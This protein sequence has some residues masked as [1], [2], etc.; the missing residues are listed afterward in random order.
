MASETH[1][2]LDARS[3]SQIRPVKLRDLVPHPKVQ[4]AFRAG[5][6]A[7]IAGRLDLDALGYPVVSRHGN[8]YHVIDGQHRVEALKLFGFL[9]DDLVECQVYVDLTEQQEAELFLRRNDGKAV[10]A[11]SGFH[12]A[13][14][15]G[16]A[17]ETTISDVVRQLG[18]RIGHR[19]RGRSADAISAVGTLKAVYGRVGDSGLAKTLRIIRDAYG[20]AALEAPIIDGLGLC[21]QR[22][23]GTLDEDTMITALST[24]AGGLHGLVN[25][26]E[27][28]RVGMGQSRQQCIA[29]TAVDLY[30]RAHGLKKG[31]LA[32]WWKE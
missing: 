26:A 8:I 23:D 12:V 9:P 3:P 11:L 32:P 15:A 16:R 21:V 17:D 27:K 28:T 29:A 24:A 13:I 22:Y 4:R 18:L 7:K 30:N 1:A 10:D 14:H 5:H 31:R 25:Q 19:G 6:A 20:N 2:G